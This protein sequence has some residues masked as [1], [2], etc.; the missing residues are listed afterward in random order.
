MT[1]PEPQRAAAA[2]ECATQPTER[3]TAQKQRVDPLLRRL[4]TSRGRPLI[5]YWTSAV[6]KL[7][8]GVELPW[9]DQLLQVSSQHEQARHDPLSRGVDILLHTAGGDTETPARLISM[10]REH[11]AHVAVLIPY[12][13]QSAGT[14]LALG[15]DEIVMSSMASLGPIAPS[16]IHPLL[17]QKSA[18][19][20]PDAVAVQELHYAMEFIRRTVGADNPPSAK[21]WAQIFSA[22]FDKI[23]PLAIGAIEQSYALAKFVTRRCLETHMD[24]HT[25]KAKISAIIDTLC[26]G[27]QSH[28][29]RIGRREAAEIGL[30]IV[31]PEADV[32]RLM[33]EIFAH[34]N[35]RPFRP[36]VTTARKN[37]E[38][39]SAHIAWLEST[40]AKHRCTQK[41][42]AD[43]NNNLTPAGDQWELY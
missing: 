25:H 24:A 21:A 31:H 13:A 16:R 1:L 7:S 10:V 20:P 22:L 29:Y 19:E 30:N 3:E 14:M 17:P 5:V 41:F 8:A 6:A 23:H 9:M 39:V 27:Y 4:E 2:P 15:A 32:E 11:V 38:P 33:L 26:D 34:Y 42:T 40:K 36:E 35:A 28:Q 12:I 18:S 43:E 37:N